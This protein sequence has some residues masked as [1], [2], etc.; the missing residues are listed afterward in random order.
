MKVAVTQ[1]SLESSK[2]KNLSKALD[3]IKIA[4][5]C[6]LVVL[7][8]MLMGKRTDNVELY[9]MAEDVTEGHFAISLREAAREYNTTVCA[10]L[11]ED[12]GS[13]KVYNTA[14]A[15]GS[16]G[17]LL[18]KYRKLHLFDALSVKESDF[19]LSGDELP[20]VFDCCGVKCGLS[21]CYDLRFPEIYR[22][23]VNDGAQLFVIPAAWYAGEMKVNHLHTLLSARA[24]ENTSYALCSNLCGDL[25]AGYSAAFA[26]FG[27]K[28]NSL[29]DKEGIFTFDI[30]ITY[31]D[32][33]REKIP[34]LANF[35][36]DIFS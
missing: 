12:T 11:W 8:E 9:H 23:L 34:C 31:V 28:I 20:P 33:I 4:S 13:D 15:F 25:F 10:C 27:A 35:R 3:C 29:E 24:I 30:D 1:M 5:D 17:R 36:N 26:P 18:A 6:D 14:V 16:D 7:P 19:M 2:E 22:S 21:I 32:E